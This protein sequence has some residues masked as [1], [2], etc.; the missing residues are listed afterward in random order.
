MAAAERPLSRFTTSTAKRPR[1]DE[2]ESRRGGV[3][4]D[5][6]HFTLPTSRGPLPAG[7]IHRFIASGTTPRFSYA[8]FGPAA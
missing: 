3:P 2:S 8:R 1:W 7:L 4:S 5:A 6:R